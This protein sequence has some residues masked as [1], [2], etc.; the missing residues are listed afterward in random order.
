[1]CTM[2][3]PVH[4]LRS[5][6]TWSA[7]SSTAQ[8]ERART[9]RDQAQ[10]CSPTAERAGRDTAPGGLES[11]LCGMRRHER[12]C[13]VQPRNL[14]DGEQKAGRYRCHRRST[15]ASHR[16]LLCRADGGSQTRTRESIAV[17]SPAIADGIALREAVWFYGIGWLGRR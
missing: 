14:V 4:E 3:R 13:T 7:D 16:R 10:R 9:G 1:M 5:T 2:N 6:G 15:T 11:R 12:G 17:A 8:V